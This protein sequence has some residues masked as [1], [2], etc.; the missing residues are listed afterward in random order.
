[1]EALGG[2]AEVA[3]LGECEDVADLAELR[4]RSLSAVVINHAPI[5]IGRD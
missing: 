2:T 1:V 5:D 3:L 4:D